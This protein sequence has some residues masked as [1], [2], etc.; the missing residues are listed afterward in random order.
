LNDIRYP[1]INGPT[2]AAQLQQVRSY[3]HQLVDQLNMT[4]QD[5]GGGGYSAYVA[6][7]ATR[8]NAVADKQAQNTFNAIKSLI[9]KSADIVNAY[10]QEINHR[11]E[12]VYVAESDF[13]DFTEQTTHDI[14]A[15]SDRTEELFSSLQTVISRVD[16]IASQT[17]EANA[18]INS[19]LLYT[20][21]NGVPVFGLEIGQTNK[22]DGA[23]VFDK[24]ARFT[25][26]KLSFYDQ[27]DNE[28]AYI[29][30]RKLY[31]THVEVTGTFVHGKFKD[32]VQ[33]DG[34]VVTKW[35]GV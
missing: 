3:L 22:V 16:G 18:Y 31:I 27:N 10:Y 23:D 12:G 2:E 1:N 11:L 5:M 7:T 6:P 13:G 15:T 9:I 35:V 8:S 28:V 30:D 19:G 21:E 25:A 4:L 29:S 20:D 26:D 24:F 17:I 32:V 33:L 14:K 34:T